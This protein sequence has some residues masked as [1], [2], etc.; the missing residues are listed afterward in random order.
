ML[1]MTGN[2]F[3]M[4]SSTTISRWTSM[5]ML[6]LGNKVTGN[7]CCLRIWLFELL[8]EKFSTRQLFCDAVFEQCSYSLPVI[9]WAA[10]VSNRMYQTILE[11]RSNYR[12]SDTSSAF[13]LLSTLMQVKASL[14]QYKSSSSLEHPTSHLRR[15]YPYVCCYQ[16]CDCDRKNVWQ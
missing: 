8:V 16:L 6:A 5:C 15:F 1:T 3:G 2:R 14:T 9:T 4:K 13:P 10:Q 12:S 7:L 11:W